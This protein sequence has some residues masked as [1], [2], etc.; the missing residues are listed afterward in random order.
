MIAWGACGRREEMSDGGRREGGR[1]RNWGKLQMI[2]AFSIF[3]VQN[4]D[5]TQQA[6]S[7]IIKGGTVTALTVRIAIITFSDGDSR[8]LQSLTIDR[9]LGR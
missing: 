2:P 6:A 1:S 7:Q 4:L 5:P 3:T 8:I 9:Y